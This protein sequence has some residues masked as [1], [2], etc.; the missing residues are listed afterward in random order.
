MDKEDWCAVVY[1]VA[2]LVMTKE[3]NWTELE[4]CEEDGI[5]MLVYQEERLGESREFS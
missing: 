5:T 4:R 1:G 2:E 3:L